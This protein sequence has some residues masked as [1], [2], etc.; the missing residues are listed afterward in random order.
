MATARV[1]H[2][3][4]LLGSG[5]VLEAGGENSTTQSRTVFASAEVFD[6]ATGTS[7]TT[8]SMHTTRAEFQMI[9][10]A[11]GQVLVAG[12]DT[13]SSQVTPTTAAESYTP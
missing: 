8:G 4:A 6:P 10:L 3:T 1:F 9:P 5:K 2:S 7:S 13:G 12:G 11:N